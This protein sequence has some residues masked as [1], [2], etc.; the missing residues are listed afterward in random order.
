MQ[1]W[2]GGGECSPIGSAWGGGGSGAE[3]RGGGA[4]L[5]ARTKRGVLFLMGNKHQGIVI[6]GLVVSSWA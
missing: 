5:L 1:Y 4:L 6:S 3:A 2:V